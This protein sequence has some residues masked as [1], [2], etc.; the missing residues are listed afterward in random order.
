MTIASTLPGRPAATG[1][2]ACAAAPGPIAGF[3][4]ALWKSLERSGQRRA[5]G[6]L[7]RLSS[8]YAGAQ[9]EL[10]RAMAEAADDAAAAARATD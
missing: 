5:A 6:E 10:A 4:R 3:A 7:R 8:L 9:P 1:G 2:R